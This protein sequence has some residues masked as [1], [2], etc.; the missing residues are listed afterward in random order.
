MPEENL[1]D[2]LPKT[3]TEVIAAAAKSVA[4]ANGY[5]ISFNTLKGKTYSIVPVT[6]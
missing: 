6:K 1:D 2:K 4:D 3:A 5:I